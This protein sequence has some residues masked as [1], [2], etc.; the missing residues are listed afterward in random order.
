[1]QEDSDVAPVV[2]KN[3][4]AAQ[5]LHISVPVVLLNFPAAH[6]VQLVQSATNSIGE[7]VVAVHPLHDPPVEGQ[8]CNHDVTAR[9]FPT[10]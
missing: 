7:G 9:G 6:A 2:S 3:L 4:P 10:F 1:M 5:L 8:S